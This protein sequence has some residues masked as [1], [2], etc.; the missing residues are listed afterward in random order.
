MYVIQ[1]ADGTYYCGSTSQLQRRIDE[2]N[3]GKGAR[4][5]KGRRPVRLVLQL[6]RANRSE[7]QKAEAAFKKLGR[8][9]KMAAIRGGTWL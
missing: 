4:Y 7:A 9:A 5:T 8:G 1:C 6:E 2:H 3:A